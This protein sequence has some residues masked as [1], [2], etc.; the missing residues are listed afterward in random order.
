MQNFSATNSI[1]RKIS[2]LVTVWQP[3]SIPPIHQGRGRSPLVCLCL[4][5]FTPAATTKLSSLLEICHPKVDK[6][7]Q[8]NHLSLYR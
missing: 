8:P 7:A 6:R 4:S 1:L 2:N 5:S 3:V